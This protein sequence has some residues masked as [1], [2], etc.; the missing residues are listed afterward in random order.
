M[1]EQVSFQE[2]KTKGFPTQALKYGYK[3]NSTLSP[4]H[5]IE[6]RHEKTNILHM[7]KQRRRSAP[8][9]SLHR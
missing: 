6:P 7:R 4:S 9:F 8:L 2:N 5:L 1:F 3:Y